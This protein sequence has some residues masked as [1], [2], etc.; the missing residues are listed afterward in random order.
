MTALALAGWCAA[1]VPAIWALT[2]RRRLE[3][4]ARAE[5]ELRGP[6]AAFVL[7]LEAADRGSLADGRGE[8]LRVELDRLRL[9]LADLQAARSGK[10]APSRPGPV[11]LDRLVAGAA[12]GWAPAARRAG[13]G[14]RLDWR[15]GPVRMLADRA[16]LSQ[17]VSNVLS[18]AVE[19]GGG[20]VEI[21]ASPAPHGVRVEV[22]DAG[23]GFAD[24]R[25]G[26]RAG[27]G[28]GLA[29]AARAV[30]EAG[31]RLSVSSTETGSTVA[32][33]L[34]VSDG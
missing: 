20:S 22:K 17:A 18:N 12:Q 10:R 23:P 29:I 8:A 25:S 33:D 16:R 7:W 11:S 2:L 26:R 28:R 30:E 27:R 24:R 15:A 34:P 1:A 9:G 14:V 5:H 31:G 3:L 19:H 6:V 4:V 13:G 32:L 21:S